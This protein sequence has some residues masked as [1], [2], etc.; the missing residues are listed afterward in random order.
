MVFSRVSIEFGTSHPVSSALLVDNEAGDI[1][2]QNLSTEEFNCIGYFPLVE[3]SPR[4]GAF[5]YT[6]RHYNVYHESAD[7]RTRSPLLLSGQLK[8][9]RLYQLPLLLFH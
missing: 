2:L 5:S 8:M 3:D 6:V 9:P 1:G 4:S 7:A